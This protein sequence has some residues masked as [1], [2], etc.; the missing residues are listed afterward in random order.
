MIKEYVIAS[1]SK[2]GNIMNQD[3]ETEM[4]VKKYAIA[5]SSKAGK[6]DLVDRYA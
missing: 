2:V 3:R 5:G 4:M 1:L 6:L